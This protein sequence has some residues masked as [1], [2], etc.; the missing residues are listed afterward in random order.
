V[1]SCFSPAD[2]L[3]DAHLKCVQK[4]LARAAGEISRRIG[5]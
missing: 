5:A 1:L 4:I 3:P 2:R